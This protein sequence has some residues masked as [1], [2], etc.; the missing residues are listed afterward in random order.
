MLGAAVQEGRRFYDDAAMS[1]QSPQSVRNDAFSRSQSWQLPK[2]ARAEPEPRKT[3]AGEMEI[4][5]QR[6][7]ERKPPREL[8]RGAQLS[9]DDADLS[10]EGESEVCTGG[11]RWKG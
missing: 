7:I 3:S 5:S 11:G 2:A 4:R 1:N 6:H 10:D 8:G 9:P